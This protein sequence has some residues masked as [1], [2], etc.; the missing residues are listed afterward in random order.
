[1]RQH[2]LSPPSLR[3]AIARGW[4]FS[5]NASASLANESAQAGDEPSPVDQLAAQVPN[6]AIG[7]I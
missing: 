6:A 7:A 2:P 4:F 3:R 5:L 1:M